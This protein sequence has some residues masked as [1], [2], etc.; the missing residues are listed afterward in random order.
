VLAKQQVPLC[1][2]LVTRRLMQATRKTAAATV[3]VIKFNNESW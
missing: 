1:E 2:G 3:C